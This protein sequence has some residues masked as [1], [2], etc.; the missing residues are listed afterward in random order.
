MLNRL[1]RFVKNNRG[2]TMLEFVISFMLLLIIW[3]GI[4]N[5]GLL[6]KERLAVTAAV[7]EAGREAA[8]S[9]N[10]YAGI[11]RGYQVLQAEGIGPERSVVLVYQPAANLFAVEVTCRS[12]LFLPLLNGLMGGSPFASELT[13]QETKYYRYEATPES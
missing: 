8:V 13:L 6:F 7:R 1:R 3:G 4:C 9:G 11:D 10:L 2:T 12:P 5:F